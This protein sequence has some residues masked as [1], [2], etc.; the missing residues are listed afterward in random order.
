MQTYE[1]E[2]PG[3]AKGAG[4]DRLEDLIEENETARDRE[5]EELWT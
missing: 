5:K 4:V 1:R 2:V 3:T